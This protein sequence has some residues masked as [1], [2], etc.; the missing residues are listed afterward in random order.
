MNLQTWEYLR[1]N[2]RL[3]HYESLLRWRCL[4]FLGHSSDFRHGLELKYFAS[5][6]D[7][8]MRKRSKSATISHPWREWQLV[9]RFWW[10]LSNVRDIELMFFERDHFGSLNCLQFDNFWLYVSTSF[11]LEIVSLVPG[12][13]I[14]WNICAL[15]LIQF[16]NFVLTD[17]SWWHQSHKWSK[18]N[19]NDQNLQARETFASIQTSPGFQHRLTFHCWL[20]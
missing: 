7:S 5:W 4:N 20:L 14:H 17:F 15:L 12:L 10:C 8:S 2:F 19:T 3:C 13:Q 9:R 11:L 16:D 6:M 18:W 1:L